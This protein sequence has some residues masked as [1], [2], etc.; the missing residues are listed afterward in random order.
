MGNKEVNLGKKDKEGERVRGGRRG[1]IQGGERR[2]GLIFFQKKSGKKLPCLLPSCVYQYNRIA[3]LYCSLDWIPFCSF[4]VFLLCN[5]YCV[6]LAC[7]MPGVKV[8]SNQQLRRVFSEQ[9][10]CTVYL[11][12]AWIIATVQL[13]FLFEAFPSLHIARRV[14]P[15]VIKL[16]FTVRRISSFSG[17][18]LY[19]ALL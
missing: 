17:C 2:E 16:C 9:Y 6:H 13:V 3:I 8:Y 15:V 14:A 1:R 19:C 10:I 18:Y 12:T 5:M 7:R 11:Q 4:T